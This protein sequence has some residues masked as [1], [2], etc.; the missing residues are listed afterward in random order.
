[1]EEKRIEAVK[2]LAEV[3]PVRNIQVFFNFANLYYCFIKVFSKIA[4]LLILKLKI[5]L[6][7][8][9]SLKKATTL[10]SSSI[11]NVSSSIGGSDIIVKQLLKAF[12]MDF[13]TFEAQIAF[14]Q[15][16]KAF[17]KALILHHSNPKCHIRIE[18]DDSDYIIGRVFNQLI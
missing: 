17:T 5:L 2:T 7:F 3:K 9:N 6:A 13:F 8:T 14:C 10:A 4:A 18:I 12:G 1:M 16:Q 11:A 15:L